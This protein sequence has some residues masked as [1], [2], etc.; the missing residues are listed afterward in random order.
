MKKN[1]IPTYDAIVIGSGAAGYSAAC[2]LRESGNLLNGL[3]GLVSSSYSSSMYQ[4]K[5]LP[6]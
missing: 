5:M 6:A 2:R 1:Y 4:R 3:Y